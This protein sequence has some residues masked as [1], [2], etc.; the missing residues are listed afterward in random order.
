[1]NSTTPVQ[2]S[3]LLNRL[4]AMWKRIVNPPNLNYR[5]NAAD[6]VDA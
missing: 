4:I 3:T 1:M 5:G 6:Y 2:A